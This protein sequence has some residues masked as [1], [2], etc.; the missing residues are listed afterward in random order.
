MSSKPNTLHWTTFE[1]V[2]FS[3][4]DNW[5]VTNVGDKPST[6]IRIKSRPE[7][8]HIKYRIPRSSH[9]VRP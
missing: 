1:F 2:I 7:T 4:L 6:T 8:Q 9:D 5:Q 3:V